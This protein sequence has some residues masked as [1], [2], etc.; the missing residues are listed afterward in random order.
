MKGDEKEVREGKGEFLLPFHPFL[1]F[2]EFIMS[3]KT[4]IF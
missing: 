2:L 3:Q 4:D 1:P